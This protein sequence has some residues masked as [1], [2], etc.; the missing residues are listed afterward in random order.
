[1]CSVECNP[2]G[3]LMACSF[4]IRNAKKQTVH[5]CF[6]AFITSHIRSVWCCG[7]YLAAGEEQTVL[8][9]SEWGLHDKEC[10]WLS[11]T[12]TNFSPFCFSLTL[13]LHLCSDAF[14]HC[15]AVMWTRGL[16]LCHLPPFSSVQIS[17]QLRVWYQLAWNVAA[18]SVPTVLRSCLSS[19]GNLMVWLKLICQF[20]Y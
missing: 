5:L 1:M 3:E 20:C 8:L 4:W 10:S 14:Y 18:L 16:W 11:I 13:C 17:S 9:N 12:P 7:P 6:L 19:R 2:G 15:V